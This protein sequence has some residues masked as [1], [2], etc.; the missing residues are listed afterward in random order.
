MTSE[1]PPPS[2]RSASPHSPPPSPSAAPPAQA[3]SPAQAIAA[4]WKNESREEQM[5]WRRADAEA[6]RQYNDRR[7]GGGVKPKMGARARAAAI[8]VREEEAKRT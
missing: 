2:P 3:L 5:R 1:S 4:A 8:W 6:A 7:R